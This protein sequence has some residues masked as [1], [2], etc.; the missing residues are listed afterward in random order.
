MTCPHCGAPLKEGSSYCSHCANQ[1]N[2]QTQPKTAVPWWVKLLSVVIALSA[3]LLGWNTFTAHDDVGENIRGQLTALKNNHI[4]EAYY[5]Y[6]SQNFETNVPLRSFQQFVQEFPILTKNKGITFTE[7]VVQDDVASL[8]GTLTSLE[9]V[10]VPIEYTLVKEKEK[11]KIQKIEFPPP[12]YSEAVTKLLNDPQSMRAVV[13]DQ[14]KALK[15]N[16][17]TKAYSYGSKEF[18][19]A[20]DLEAFRKFVSRFPILTQYDSLDFQ[21]TNLEDGN[22]KV[23]LQKDGSTTTLEFIL[24]IED[25]QWKIWGFRV[26]R[27]TN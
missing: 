18:K 3:L 14:L 16:D 21:Q 15:A 9:N 22:L 5:E 7:R 1:D 12:V 19:E 17:L 4:T 27:S 6:S 10:K 26:L 2:S 25:E 20:T 8:K 11:W 13:E 23:N 24:G